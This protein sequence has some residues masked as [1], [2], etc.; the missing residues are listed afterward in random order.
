MSG[1]SKPDRKPRG[2]GRPKLDADPLVHINVMLSQASLDGIDQIVADRHGST[3]RAAVI[4][5]LIASALDARA[6]KGGKR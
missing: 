3:S 2:P 1:M 5:E 6:R 4:R